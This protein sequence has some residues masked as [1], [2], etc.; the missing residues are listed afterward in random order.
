MSKKSTGAT[1]Y[2]YW[3][4]RD[5]QN[6][7]EIFRHF[8]LSSLFR[9][10][11]HNSWT[12]EGF[13]IQFCSITPW[14]LCRRALS[15]SITSRRFCSFRTECWNKCVECIMNLQ[16]FDQTLYDDWYNL[17]LSSLPSKALFWIYS[18]ETSTF[19]SWEALPFLC[20][21]KSGHLWIQFR[22]R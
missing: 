14:I 22:I 21:G 8:L 13:L 5:Y 15:S 9:V 16:G 20:E 19:N 11:L 18:T 12:S 7:Q 10:L 1:Q 3:D 6:L 2:V 17:K 4:Y